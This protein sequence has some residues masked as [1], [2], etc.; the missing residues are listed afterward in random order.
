MLDPGLAPAPI[1]VAQAT[2]LIAAHMPRLP[3][4][5]VALADAAGE[6]LGENIVAE[7]DQPPFDR[8]TMDGIAVAAAAL[9]AGR[10]EFRILGIQA[11]GAPAQR[12]DPPQGCFEVM[13]GSVLPTGTDTV[14]PVERIRMQAG[15]ARLEDGYH[16]QPGQCVHRRGSDHRSGETL[17]RAGC[18][19]G[20]PEMAI[21]T[22]G[23]KSSVT[24]TRQPV[25]GIVST[26][27][28]LVAPGAAIEAHQIRASNDLALLAALRG[29]GL[30]G[31][32][33]LLLRDDPQ[34]LQREIGRLHA[35]CDL[36]ILSGGV[37]MGRFDHVPATLAALGIRTLFHKVRQRPGLPMW[38]GH[39]AAGKVVFALPG[40][41]VSSLVC[42]RRYV[43][44]ALHHALGAPPAPE[45]FVRLASAVD[46]TPD[47]TLFLPVCLREQA[48]GSTEALPRPTNTSGDFVA[49]GGT[50]GFVELPRGAAH[51][52]AG[53][54]ARYFAW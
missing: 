1:D 47:L 12:L 40:N 34:L 43:V 51:F 33:R 30:T 23:G 21:L 19:I 27:D 48:D 11:A 14:I 39:D 31:V 42:L 6:I 15:I 36:L 20:P 54:P 22:L 5:V 18:R 44:P 52:P 49:L 24:V 38:F 29:R 41:P 45:R 16:P 25:I 32:T 13:T 46:F 17:L 50:D 4:A 35:Q 9:A 10:R 37:S 28:E 8:V 3:T 2:Q 26:G 53:F 7:R